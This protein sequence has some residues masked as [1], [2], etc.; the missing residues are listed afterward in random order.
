MIDL[1]RYSAFARY[2]GYRALASV[3]T[4][5]GLV[6]L[7][8]VISHMIPG[9]PA[10]TVIGP[11]RN[12]QE[13]QILEQEMGLN[14]PLYIQFYNYLAGLVHGNLGYSFI[15]Q[16]SVSSLVASRFPASLELAIA[17]VLIGI[18]VALFLGLWTALRVNRPEDHAVRV[19]SLLGIS[20]PVFWVGT[21][22]ILV[23]YSF[24]H[25]LP[26]S[27]QLDPALSP[28]TTITGMYI[29][30]SAFTGNFPDLVS[31][32]SHI[33]LPALTLSIFTIAFLSRIV[34]S[35]MLDVLGTDYIRTSA[36]IGLPRNVIVNKYA[37]RNALLPAITV[38]ALT[39]AGLIAGVVLTETVFGWI[40]LGY[41]AFQSI[42]GPD[43]PSLIAVVLISGFLFVIANFIADILYAVV[44]P[45]V[46]L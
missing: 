37:L 34:R 8:F 10:L 9:N 44:D 22:L 14:K 27:G 3:P 16:Q 30:D 21:E 6:V 31:S 40:G 29:L 18:P 28:P 15:Q 39:V 1:A 5:L 19:F 4:I 32:L 26:A 23:F 36:A 17:S 38:G 41:L 33:V 46:R 13:L 45:R 35:G 7:T 11:E 43:Y 24:F 12:P 2:M 20:M 25:L 42:E